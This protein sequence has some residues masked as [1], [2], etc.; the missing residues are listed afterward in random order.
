MYVGLGQ[1][2]T[3]IATGATSTAGSVAGAHAGSIA[4]AVGLH[5]TWAV[6][7]VGAA[8]AGVTLAITA[9]LNRAGPRQKVATTKIVDEA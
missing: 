4:S 6:P 7:V 5:A 3:R 1:T 8:I 9:W 2:G